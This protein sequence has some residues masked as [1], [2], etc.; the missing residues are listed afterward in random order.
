MHR[1]TGW[2]VMVLGVTFVPMAVAQSPADEKLAK[3]IDC[4]RAEQHIASLEAEKATSSE[5]AS[6]GARTILPPTLIRDLIRGDAKE[7]ARVGTGLYNQQIDQKIYEI[8]RECAEL[9]YL[10]TRNGLK[11][12]EQAE[13]GYAAEKPGAD[14]SGYRELLILPV[15][16]TFAG[17][18]DE[19]PEET[20]DEIRLAFRKAFVDELAKGGYRVVEEA[21][22]DVLAVRAALLNVSVKTL[23]QLQPKGKVR[24]GE[25]AKLTLLA[26]LRDARSGELLG[27]AADRRELTAPASA[28]YDGRDELSQDVRDLFA[29]WARLLRERLDASRELEGT[30]TS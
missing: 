23:T 29:R 7:N 8:R 3:P 28:D 16:I 10:V 9:G 20:V 11:G 26:E 5:M 6:A 19:L 24:V 1:F 22:D 4:S 30:R 25:S 21:D 15:Y 13:V 27:R 12:L 18:S 17:D 2:L 14:L